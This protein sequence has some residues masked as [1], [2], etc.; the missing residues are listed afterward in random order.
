MSQ[1]KKNVV[2]CLALF[3]R[4]VTRCEHPYSYLYTFHRHLLAFGESNKSGKPIFYSISVRFQGL[5]CFSIRG[6]HCFPC[7]S[8]IESNCQANS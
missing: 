5:K 8:H 2:C 1:K 6:G 4:F 3:V 7:A